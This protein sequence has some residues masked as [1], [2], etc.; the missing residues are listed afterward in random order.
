MKGKFEGAEF[1]WIE[2]YKIS[3]CWVPKQ[4]FQGN[5]YVYLWERIEAATP[6]KGTPD[7]GKEGPA[8]RG[9]LQLT[10]DDHVYKF[11]KIDASSAQLGA[12][13]RERYRLFEFRYDKALTTEEKAGITLSNKSKRDLAKTALG[14]DYKFTLSGGSQHLLGF[15]ARVAASGANVFRFVSL[16]TDTNSFLEKIVEVN[17]QNV[18]QKKMSDFTIKF[19]QGDIKVTQE[20]LLAF[21]ADESWGSFCKFGPAPLLDLSSDQPEQRFVRLDPKDFSAELLLQLDAHHEHHEESFK[22]DTV[23]TATL[24]FKP[25]TYQDFKIK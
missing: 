14:D 7:L 16:R 5:F 11:E 2:G 17:N 1:Q 9:T 19:P 3:A 10:D 6:F 12:T 13:R 21:Y 15:R 23:Q 18:D 25:G 8:K 22:P 4:G 24:V 20:N